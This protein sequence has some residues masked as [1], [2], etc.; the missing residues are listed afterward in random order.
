MKDTKNKMKNYIFYQ[1]FSVVFFNGDTIF[2]RSDKGNEVEGAVDGESEG[3]GD[4]ENEDEVSARK[5]R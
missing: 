3:A 5:C 1:S 4:D 2:S